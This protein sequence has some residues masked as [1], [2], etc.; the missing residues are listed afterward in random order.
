MGISAIL[1]TLSNSETS[2][3]C[4]IERSRDIFACHVERNRDI[5]QQ[6]SPLALLGRYDSVAPGR[7]DISQAHSSGRT[8]VR[9]SCP[10]RWNESL[11][12]VLA[13]DGVFWFFPA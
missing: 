13:N 5:G 3:V 8:A 7:L 10:D 11:A 4:H 12:I 2:L 9:V 6:I 1:V